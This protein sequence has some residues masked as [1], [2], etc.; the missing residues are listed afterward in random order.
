MMTFFDSIILGI[1]EGITEFLPISSTGHLVLTSTILGIPPEAFLKTFQIAIQFGAIC[2]VLLLYWKLF[3]NPEVLKRLAVAFIPTAAIGFLM[4]GIIKSVFLESPMIVVSALF[5]GGVALIV[6]EL[7][8]K[9]PADATESVEKMT[10]LHAGLIG[11]FQSVAI[12]PGVSRSA[13][14]IVGGLLLG[15]KRV[16]IVEFSFLLAVPTMAAA[17]G[18]D[19]LKNASLF[20]FDQFG[21][22]ATGFVTSFVV[23][24]LAIR[25][26]LSYVKN[27][28]FIPFGIYRIVI[29]I[30]FFVF[31]L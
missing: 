1:V 2:A 19:I 11:L 5:L 25:F 21:L 26:L 4:Y 17:T 15:L 16:T 22:L 31:V 12:V 10:Y 7:L 14:T 28:S 23:A 29:A 24:L 6:F 3:L 20:S 18:Y 8:H 13:A 30:L 9:E 27:H